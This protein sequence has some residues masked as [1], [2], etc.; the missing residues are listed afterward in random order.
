MSVSVKDVQQPT[1]MEETPLKVSALD[2][3]LKC[4]CTY[5]ARKGY[6]ELSLHAAPFL[7]TAPFLCEDEKGLLEIELNWL[8]E[9]FRIFELIVGK[10]TTIEKKTARIALLTSDGKKRVDQQLLRSAIQQIKQVLKSLKPNS[11][12]LS[13]KMVFL[14]L[15][16]E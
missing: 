5:R 9:Q 1:G 15:N 16:I 3:W 8:E 13:N 4:L 14:T 11:Y 7:R 12:T 2:K 10:L 6:I